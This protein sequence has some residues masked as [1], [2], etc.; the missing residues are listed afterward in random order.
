MNKSNCSHTRL[1]ARGGESEG[2]ETE[3]RETGSET[4]RRREKERA[5]ARGGLARCCGTKP[6]SPQYARAGSPFPVRL[7]KHIYRQRAAFEYP[8]P[9]QYIAT[10]RS[11][12]AG[13]Q[14]GPHASQRELTG[15]EDGLGWGAWWW[16]ARNM[17][18]GMQVVATM[19]STVTE[20][21][22]GMLGTRPSPNS[23][24]GH[25][26]ATRAAGLR[27]EAKRLKHGVRARGGRSEDT[28][29]RPSQ[30]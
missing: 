9:P 18:K 13:D 25:N 5:E 23:C 20:L 26:K 10:S 3:G 2:R 22:E 27:Q 30:E 7:W 15:R 12:N 29:T 19:L 16:L 14:P 4:G 11:S 17:L 8:K 24:R 1:T 28:R 6:L 21:P